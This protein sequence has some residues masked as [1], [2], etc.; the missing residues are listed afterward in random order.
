MVFGRFAAAN[1][2]DINI[3]CLDMALT[4]D[5]ITARVFNDQ[6]DVSDFS[7]ILDEHKYI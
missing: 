3:H 4:T 6:S 7:D 5:D 1:T 2:Y